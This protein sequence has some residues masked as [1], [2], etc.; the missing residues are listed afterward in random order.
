MRTRRFPFGKVTVFAVTLSSG[1]GGVALAGQEAAGLVRVRPTTPMAESTIVDA[2]SGVSLQADKAI[3]RDGSD[4]V[5]PPAGAK[6]DLPFVQPQRRAAPLSNKDGLER[7][8]PKGGRI[9]LRSLGT[10]G[11]L[12]GTPVLQVPGPKPPPAAKAP[13]ATAGE[14]KKPT[15]AHYLEG[16][17]IVT[18]KK[19]ISGTQIDAFLSGQALPVV[20]KFKTLSRAQGQETL[21][22]GA[23]GKKT[24]DLIEFLKKNPLVEAVTPNYGKRPEGSL[25][26]DSLFS[27]QWPLDNWGQTG[28]VL[29]ADVDAPEAWDVTTGSSGVVVALLDTGV[30]YLHP[31][32]DGNMWTNPG[33]IPGNGIDDDGNGYVDDVYGVDTGEDDSDPMDSY[34]HGT[35][36]AGTI[37]AEGNN[38]EGVAGINWHARIMAVKGF[39]PDGYM[40]TS[41]ELEA[42]DYILNMKTRGVN[43]VAVNAS[44]GCYGCF[45]PAQK[46]AIEALGTAGI[47]FAAAAGNDANDNDATYVHYPSSYDSP[48][49][50]AVA[51]TDQNDN[52]AY[53][54][55][56]GATSVDLG[57]PGLDVLST[58]SWNSYYPAPGDLFFDDMESGSGNWWW[59]DTP[60]AITSEQFLSASN[61]WS[62]SPGGNYADNTFSVLYT[63]P[64][65][66]T[67]QSGPLALGFNARF[68]LEYS[69]DYLDIYAYLPTGGGSP[70]VWSITDEAYWSPTHSWSDSPAG[71]YS[72]NTENWLISPVFP[73]SGG[74]ALEEWQVTA[75]QAASGAYAWSDSPGGNYSNNT[76]NQLFSPVIDLSAAGPSADLRVD[77]ML[78]GRTE[79]YYDSLD[80]YYSGDGGASWTYITSFNGEIPSWSWALLDPIPAELRTSQFRVAFV[81]QTDS[82]VTYDGYYLD[83]VWVYDWTTSHAYFYDDMESGE[84]A[85]SHYNSAEGGSSGA[86]VGFN[87]TGNAES[88]WDYL[89]MLCSGDGGSTWS[90]LGS[91]SGD[92][93][94]GWA[95]AGAYL[96]PEC[97]TPQARVAFQFTSDGSITADGYHLD[98][99]YVYDYASSSH[100]LLDDVEAGPSGWAAYQGNSGGVGQWS[101]LGG[102]TGYSGGSWYGYSVNIPEEWR[103]NQFQ[104]AFALNSDSSNNYDGVYLDDVGIGAQTL[105]RGYALMSGTSMAA[106][107]VTGAAALLAAQFPDDTAVE[108]RQR[109]LDGVDP[110]DGL[111]GVV[112]TG[113]RLNL[114]SIVVPAPDTDGDGVP[115]DQDNCTLVA[116][117]DQRDTNSDGYGNLCDPDL[118]NDGIVNFGDLAAMKAVWLTADADADLDDSGSVNFGDLARLKSMWLQAPGPS[119]YH[120]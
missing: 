49:L 71:N 116:N 56:Y 14:T 39:R 102:I 43:I 100:A 112:A 61:A 83:D 16:E 48:N 93:S 12:C 94:T 13:G 59:W 73:L 78:R 36:V 87:F 44:Y 66:L 119:A 27:Y 35:H 103:W 11:E 65:D 81:L 29:D 98:D 10:P 20:R 77:F 37:A 54:S 86:V 104:V 53:F 60:W 57:A 120:P 91:L 32:L 118:N 30:D 33:E 6:S 109:I 52:L 4:I 114:A 19:G 42:M 80:I 18:F 84:G 2:S 31:D 55:N 110:L 69:W 51:A 8:E 46:A 5:R 25:P 99:L 24:V 92:Y 62:D 106:P 101:Y 28:G 9:E 90:Y 1:L 107:H 70:D 75:E 97:L 74:G 38:G 96:A 26:N 34:G 89:N 115:D 95:G 45:D 68:N 17:V 79:V 58:Y 3:K 64:I 67:D 7:K 47:V 88:G 50:L 111:T 23:V 72:N 113:G 21:V 82:S 40:Y 108:R 22:V 76:F 117:P 85:W 63:N 105:T 41:D 15:K